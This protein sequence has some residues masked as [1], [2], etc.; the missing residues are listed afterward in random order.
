[1]NNEKIN[2]AAIVG[3]LRTLSYNR[4]LLRAA[5]ELKPE[6][7]C[8]SELPIGDLP[9]FNE[10]LEE[11]P[12]ATVVALRAGIQQADAVL[13]ITPEYNYSIPGVLKNALDWASRPSANHV[14]LG[15]PAA[16]MGAS[17]GRS[18]TMRAQLHLRQIF[19]TLDIRA[20]NK[21]EIYIAYAANHFDRESNLVTPEFRDQV[22]Q[23][24]TNLA[25]W[26]LRMRE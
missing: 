3:S 19:T 13:F 5:A 1:M 25:E 14:L 20:L 16:I 21:P 11:D 17:G 24:M 23:L 15:K 8:L 4:G 2:V 12:P 26:A 18:A 6:S 22:R 9:L 7:I 10:E